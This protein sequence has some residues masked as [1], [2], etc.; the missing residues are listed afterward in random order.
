MHKSSYEL[1][2]QF[3]QQI[4]ERAAGRLIRVLDVGS[5]GVNGTYKDLFIFPGAEYVGLDI[6]AG[7]NVDVVPEDPYRW[8]A[9]PDNSF[10]VI[11]SGQALEHIEFPWLIFEQIA[12][13]L[14]PMGLACLIAPS[15]GPEHRYPVDC[16]RYYPDGLRAL[17]KWSG[18]NVVE[19]EYTRGQSGFGADSDQWGDCRCILIKDVARPE[20]H[21]AP[22]VPMSQ[23]AD[24]K[25]SR[26]GSNP[27]N[28]SSS[29]YFGYARP[30]VIQLI[31]SLGIS[32]GRVL[33]LG[34]AGGA[35]A[36]EL[37]KLLAVERYVGI[38]VERSIADQAHAHISEVH[39]ADINTADPETI[40][41]KDDSFDLLLALDVLEHLYNPWDILERYGRLLARGGHAV[42]SIPNI[43]N[44]SI[45]R[46]LAQG[47]WRYQSAGL[48]DATH[49]R[50]FSREG[51]SQLVSG[52]GLSLVHVN[53]VLNPR[54]D[55][56][57]LRDTG[58]TVNLGSVQISNVSKAEVLNLCTYQFLVVARR[59]SQS[60]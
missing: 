27:L 39:V 59:P 13:K 41:L 10:D 23:R 50:F 28:L 34:C 32:V 29:E 30:E 46:Q 24:K 54:P 56:A 5:A 16:Y 42:L 1:M 31:S 37:K 36:R 44:V 51:V 21:Q 15:R 6:Q 25:K 35:T 17:A 57:Q 19:C 45:I 33:E 40:G 47:Q 53:A 43:A 48:L 60:N 18:L 20:A 4:R 3:A 55:M 11:I 7:P 9:L 58:N 14:K 12:R 26:H 8:T 38:E 52:A 2:R 49:V 22:V